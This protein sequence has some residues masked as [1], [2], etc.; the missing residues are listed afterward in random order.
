V[1]A[2]KGGVVTEPHR[3]NLGFNIGVSR[4]RE[5][6]GAGRPAKPAEEER[7]TNAERQ[8]RFRQMRRDEL[9]ALRTLGRKKSFRRNA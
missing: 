5:A 8:R 9:P 6:L 1:V 7:T 4:T 3:S 2:A